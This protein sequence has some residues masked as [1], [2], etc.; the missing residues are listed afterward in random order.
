MIFLNARPFFAQAV[1]SVLDQT[2]RQWELLLVDDGSTD[3]TAELAR[4]FAARFPD[5]VRYLHHPGH[6]NLGM[7]ASR[8][9]G[10]QES[11]GSMIGFLDADD[12]WLPEKLAVQ[13]GILFSQP[14]AGMVCGPT[15]YWRSWTGRSTDR[16]SR[17]EIASTSN[18]LLQ[19]PRL[20][21]LLPSQSSKTPATCSVLIRR[22]VFELTGGF[23]PRFRTLYEDQVFFAKVY[24]QVPV[25][26]TDQCL[27]RYRQHPQSCCAQAEKSGTYHS[28]HQSQ[29][30]YDFL[31]WL[32]G[33]LLHQNLTDPLLLD[34]LQSALWPYRHPRLHQLQQWNL[35]PLPQFA[36]LLSS[37]LRSIIPRRTP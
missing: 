14:Q 25:W 33:Y 30:H 32:E 27:D 35:Q 20:V 11:S 19:H 13:T 21:P 1:Q 24:L 10:I 34:P 28:I 5:R 26:V 23:E 4:D 36:R 17:R 7:S 2:Y 8:N 6:Q 12:V 15:E 29:A 31:L 3:G 37:I 16:D 22:Q 9:L 18:C